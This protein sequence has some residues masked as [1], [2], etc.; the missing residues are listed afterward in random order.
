MASKRLILFTV[1][2]FLA[3]AVS[4]AS[5]AGAIESLKAFL[6]GTKTLTAD[7]TQQV[8]SREGKQGRPA[9]GKFELSRPNRFRFEYTL[10][11]EQVIVSD[12][13]K[14]WLYDKDL[15]QVTVRSYAEALAASP[16][17]I[18]AGSGD[19]EQHYRLKALDSKDGVDWLEATPKAK[20]S[21][22]ESF[23]LGFN[24]GE[25][26][27]MELRDSFGQTSRI[28]FASVKRNAPVPAERV[29]FF[30]P[31]GAEVVQQ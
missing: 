29:R 4:A 10:P 31:P 8:T 13:Q 9:S 30:P 15:N 21:M 17:A 16:A 28:T 11:Y 23:R 6:Q 5:A 24:A 20:D 3:L 2:L 18:L 14:L 26:V 25:L 7:F 12:G 1:S 19:V 27:A 22:F